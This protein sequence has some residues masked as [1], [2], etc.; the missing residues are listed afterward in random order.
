MEIVEFGEE[1]E[2][3]ILLIPGNMMSWKQFDEV[4]PL[5]MKDYYVIAVSLDGYD[6]TGATT[7][8]STES[9]AEKLEEYIKDSLK[10]VVPY[11]LTFP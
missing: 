10:K 8:T 11:L 4:V 2:K 7:F 1:N 6:G 5:L 9:S 3:K